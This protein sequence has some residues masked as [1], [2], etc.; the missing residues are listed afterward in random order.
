MKKDTSWVIISNSGLTGSFA[1]QISPLRM[2]LCHCLCI[3]NFF[4]LFSGCVAIPAPSKLAY[5]N[6]LQEALPL[7]QGEV[8][9]VYG[10]NAR[11][12]KHPFMKDYFAAGCVGAFE[13]DT[14]G[15]LIKAILQEN[16]QPGKF[17]VKH[18]KE[19]QPT[20]NPSP[21]NSES[22]LNRLNLSNTM[23]LSEHLRY[24]IHVKEEFED[25]THVPLYAPPFGVATCGNKTVLQA[26][27]WELPTEKFIG[28]L[29]VSS[30]G[31]YVAAGYIITIIAVP[32]TQM[33]AT[34]KLAQEIVA[35]LSGSPQDL[36]QNH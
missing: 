17:A 29:T 35:L 6:T 28:S 8:L 21:K 31:E 22:I 10:E 3:L 7:D 30:A 27:I 32:D 25:T 12:P 2:R 26:D 5:E 16:Q 34:R 24:A 15:N 33:D 14:V 18:L 23:V 36:K 11:A 20:S 13:T 4:F 19:I 1:V 9:V